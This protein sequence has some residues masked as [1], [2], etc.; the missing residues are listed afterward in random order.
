MS[1]I[2][3]N[4][5]GTFTYN[6]IIDP[7]I[8]FN[9]ISCSL[10]KSN[11]NCDFSRYTKNLLKFKNLKLIE[12]FIFRIYY[13]D[14]IL[15]DNY[16]KNIFPILNKN[17]QLVHYDC[18]AFKTNG[19]HDGMFGTLMRYMP[20]H[21]FPE[22]DV[23]MCQITELDDDFKSTEL[24]L[25]LN[26]KTFIKY[27]LNLL[28][29]YW[30]CHRP[31][32][33]INI[34]NTILGGRFLIKIKIPLEFLIHYVNKIVNKLLITYEKLKEIKKKQKKNKPK[35]RNKYRNKFFYGVDEIY[36]ELY[37]KSYIDENKIRY[38]RKVKYSFRSFYG[39]LINMFSDS[40]NKN[41]ELKLKLEKIINS[42]NKKFDTKY[43]NLYDFINIF[44]DYDWT[45][46]TNMH[47]QYEFF[48]K[49]VI[50]LYEKNPDLEKINKY[51][52]FLRIPKFFD[53]TNNLEIIN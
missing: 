20:F 32:H 53:D 49:K 1:I 9:I 6:Y 27:K 8:K 17:Y 50:K 13:D 39:L 23:N 38:G 42:I 44:K 22:N 24:Y 47:K 48:H 15:E 37:L 45:R 40:V 7:N 3:I 21:D 12:K 18:P 30:Y 43:N 51:K 33:N 2:K 28:Y 11:K 34:D 4:N 16:I 25:N 31:A 52:C 35:Y 14:S 36:T 26:I 41:N 5:L 10:F 29:T 19:E 46:K